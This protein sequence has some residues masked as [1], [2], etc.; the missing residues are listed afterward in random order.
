VSASPRY[1][2]DIWDMASAGI[3]DV[4]FTFTHRQTD[5][6]DR[7]STR[8]DVTEEFLVPGEQNGDLLRPLTPEPRGE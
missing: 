4:E 3:L 6:V 1:K 8:V 2:Q 5:A 7:H